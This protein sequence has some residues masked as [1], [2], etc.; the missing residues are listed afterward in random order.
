[1]KTLVVKI[2]DKSKYD[3][4]VELLN[5]FDYLEVKDKKELS[6]EDK[7]LLKK[8]KKSFNEVDMQRPHKKIKPSEDLPAEL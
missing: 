4:I 3:F 5:S 1:M 8:N 7:K 2:T 6:K